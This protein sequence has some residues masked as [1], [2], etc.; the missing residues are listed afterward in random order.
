M[1]SL[2]RKSR[3]FVDSSTGF[4]G[5]K[6][7]PYSERRNKKSIATTTITRQDEVVS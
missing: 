6:R 5:G 2:S 1:Q 3:I 4:I 7:R